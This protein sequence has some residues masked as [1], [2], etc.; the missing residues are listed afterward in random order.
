M[1]TSTQLRFYKAFG[2]IKTPPREVVFSPQNPPPRKLLFLFPLQKESLLE[3]RYVIQRL[4]RYLHHG[5]IYLAI[6]SIFR[7][8]ISCPPSSAFYFP[9]LTGDPLRIRMDVMLARFRGQD[10][11]AVFNLDP[12]LNFQLARVMSAVN[13]SRRV[14][15]AGP[16]ADELYNIQIHLAPDRRLKKAYAQMLKICDLDPPKEPGT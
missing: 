3:S 14:G 4:E 13:T 9:V 8:L 12:E 1:K 5:T 15:I 11:D 6:A 2:Y 7:D 10:F 16:H